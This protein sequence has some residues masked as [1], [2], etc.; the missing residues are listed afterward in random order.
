MNSLCEPSAKQTVL[1]VENQI[2]KFL[3]RIFKKLVCPQVGS[4]NSIMIT[5][6]CLL[7]LRYHVSWNAI[8][9]LY[10]TL[11]VREGMEFTAM[12]RLI[13]KRILHAVSFGCIH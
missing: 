5:V 11:K 13:Q 3:L 8:D 10:L 4:H 2:P 1:N 12:V 7:Y 9:L 6:T